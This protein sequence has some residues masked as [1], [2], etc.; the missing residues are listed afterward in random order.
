MLPRLSVGL[1]LLLATGSSAV[2]TRRVYAVSWARQ[3]ESSALVS[4]L[5]RQLRD[6]LVRR[7]ASVVEKV[8]P[9]TVVL[10]PS[11]QVLPGALRL[12]VLGVRAVDQ[13]LLGT[14]N[15][16]ASGASRTAQLKALVK[17]VGAESEALAR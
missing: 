1:I 4:E 17:H 15:A 2:S 5:D 16:K 8:G 13:Q 6:E 11:L 14:I 10:K 3:A 7:G 9:T 12:D